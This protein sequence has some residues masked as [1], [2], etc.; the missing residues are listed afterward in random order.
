MLRSNLGHHN[1]RLQ[2]L[3][4]EHQARA[5]EQ[6]RLEHEHRQLELDYQLMRRQFETEQRR[7]ARLHSRLGQMVGG[8]EEWGGGWGQK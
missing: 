2:E 5:L 1:L 8:R 3:M 4:E 7:L 6:R